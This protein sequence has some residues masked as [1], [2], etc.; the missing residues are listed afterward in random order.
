MKIFCRLC[1]VAKQSE[2]FKC[3]LDDQNYDIE[4][5]LVT[6]CNWNS[7]RS[8]HNLPQ[9][10]CIPCF[11]QLEQSW[12]FREMVARSQQKLCD[13]MKVD[14]EIDEIQVKEEDLAADETV[15]EPPIEVSTLKFENDFGNSTNFHESDGDGDGDNDVDNVGCSFVEDDDSDG[16]DGVLQDVEPSNDMKLITKTISKTAVAKVTKSTKEKVI[17]NVKEKEK[18]KRKNETPKSKKCVSNALEFDI[19]T[20]LSHEDVNENGTIK[21]EKIQAQ[22]F[23]DWNAITSRCYKCKTDF[24]TNADL[25]FHFTSSH[26]DE[27]IKFVCPICP[28]VMLFLSGRY[29]RSH[30]AKM[31]H[32]HLVYW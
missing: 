9:N 28:G 32:P 23:C 12:Y 10:V 26:P 18:V 31:H 22:N 11:L 13:L 16:D 6:C 27:K 2:E 5:K 14:I 24:D 15:E 19:K 17:E 25:W 20:V 30:I 21:P 1:A 8:H 3:K 4:Q 29:Y 7:Y